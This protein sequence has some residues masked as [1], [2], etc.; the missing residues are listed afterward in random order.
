M[1]TV[2][3]TG[4]ETHRQA[5]VVRIYPNKKQEAILR[6]HIGHSRAV[7]NL[8]LKWCVDEYNKA[9]E[10]KEKPKPVTYFNLTR[11]LT[12]F[13]QNQEFAWLNEVPVDI[14]GRSLFNLSRAY[15]NF[16]RNAKQGTLPEFRPRR[17]NLP[18]SEWPWFWLLPAGHPRLKNKYSRKVAQ[19][20][21]GVK[22]SDCGCKVHVPP[23]DFGWMRMKGWRP[24]FEDYIK[25]GATI[26]LRPSN[27]WE[28]SL[29]I[30]ADPPPVPVKNP[31]RIM[32]IHCGMVDY[33]TTFNGTEMRKIPNPG[34]IQHAMENLRRKDRKLARKKNAAEKIAKESGEKIVYSNRRE[35]MRIQRARCHERVANARKDHYRKVAIDVLRQC[36]TVVLETWGIIDMLSSDG[37]GD[38][39]FRRRMA[40]CAW[41]NLLIFVEQ[42][43]KALGKGVIRLERAFPSSLTCNVCG[44]V[45]PSLPLSKKTWSC[46]KCNTM[47]D[48]NEN[49]ARNVYAAGLEAL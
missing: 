12:T 33:I 6:M 32:A 17:T 28:M 43:A 35:G 41:G 49:A 42:K 29:S 30:L 46:P 38:N 1:D 34:F 47:H 2:D 21:R 13:K 39:V 45:L 23:Y 3:S 8:A 14:L 31:K 15:Q 22:V 18:K 40:D 44:Y 5:C 20:S 10:L 24:E 7:Y 37:D 36:D 25:G 27:R 19:Y 11:W 26:E 16:F 48:R 4:D 9:K